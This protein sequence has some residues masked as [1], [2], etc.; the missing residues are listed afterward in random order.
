MIPANSALDNDK[1]RAVFWEIFFVGE[2]NTFTNLAGRMI[3]RGPCR[4]R[5]DDKI[6]QYSISYISKTAGN[7]LLLLSN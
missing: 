5:R 6:M 3:P 1:T 7:G 4:P 2:P